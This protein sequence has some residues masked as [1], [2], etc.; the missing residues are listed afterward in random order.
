MS[1]RRVLIVDD[2]RDILRALRLILEK[3]GY[4]I[5]S[6]ETARAALELLN[7]RPFHVVISDFRLPDFDG[8]EL[9]RMVKV[10]HPQIEFIILTGYG[11]ID[12]AVQAIREGAYDFVQK[13]VKRLGVLRTL[14]KAFEK[15]DL[16]IENRKLREEITSIRGHKPII[17]N[18]P[19]MRRVI[20][21][22]E[23]VAPSTATVLITGESGTGKEVIANFI[24]QSSGRKSNP[25]V[26]VSCAAIP[27]T[28]L[29]AELFGHERGAFTGAFAQ[30]KG[31]FEVA[32]RGTLFLDEIGEVKPSTQV[33][34]LR[35][36]QEGE[37]E[38]LGGNQTLSANAR[39]IAATNVD[40]DEAVR[41][42]H[43]REDLFYR[44]NVISI[45]LPPLRDRREDI[46]FL[47][48]QSLRHW[49][50]KNERA[51]REVS[52][53]ALDRLIEYDWP[54][55]VRELENVMERAVILCRK[56]VIDVDDLP[57]LARSRTSEQGELRIPLGTS[58][59][60]AESLLITETIRH[61]R[62][63]KARAAQLLGV[64]VRTIHR[65][66]K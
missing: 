66:T 12:I 21:I 48:D 22:A 26:K 62:G 60:E 56:D 6:A 31:R 44:L 38:R 51:I 9:L 29:E 13:P 15:R 63:N 45:H 64:A 30:R 37:F 49:A 61:A 52:R 2:E 5:E 54:G 3:E 10:Q 32:G 53:D 27:E 28:L 46:P 34:L 47:V 50:A 24:H 36:L 43:F 42:K 8:M 25:F 58:L 4:E 57:A 55:N 11:T 7:A 19:E 33:K 20:D 35:V 40:L 59:R 17:A 41:D 65:R 1:D 18:S 16:L 39:I 23:Q 14:E